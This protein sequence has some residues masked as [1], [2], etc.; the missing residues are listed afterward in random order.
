MTVEISIGEIVDKLLI[1]Q[2]KKNNIKYENI[3]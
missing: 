3:N 2:I 1:L